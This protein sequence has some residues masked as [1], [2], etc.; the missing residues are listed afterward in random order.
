[1]YA[2]SVSKLAELQDLPRFFVDARHEATHDRIPPLD[3]LRELS[4]LALSWLKRTYWD[5]MKMLYSYTSASNIDDCAE[6]M[7]RI[8]LLKYQELFIKTLPYSDPK[9]SYLNMEAIP[10]PISKAVSDFYAEYEAAVFSL[11]LQRHIL[12]FVIVQFQDPSVFNYESIVWS[13]LLSPIVLNCPLFIELVVGS[14]IYL[15]STHLLLERLFSIW[16]HGHSALSVQVQIINRICEILFN[17]IPTEYSFFSISF[18][19]LIREKFFN[20]LHP[21]LLA[22]VDKTLHLDGAFSNESFESLPKAFKVP[23]SINDG[24]GEKQEDEIDWIRGWRVSPLG[25]VDPIFPNYNH[26]HSQS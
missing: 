10:R 7:V 24:I 5:G 14:L 1:M 23:P 4:V 13:H 20:L 6:D 17:H 3:Y 16:L 9:K 2:Q 8:S 26:K 12:S 22:L 21:L 18:L 19:K 15:P 25:S 11:S